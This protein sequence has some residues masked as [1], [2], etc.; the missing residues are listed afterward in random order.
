[1]V[2]GEMRKK[3][4]IRAENSHHPSPTPHAVV[5]MSTRMS[6]II[7]A[8]ITEA[9]LQRQWRLRAIYEVALGPIIDH[10]SRRESGQ[11]NRRA[12]LV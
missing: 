11:K 4:R 3:L 8:G 10:N 1:M 6:E 2:I 7:Q 12:K 9:K 5:S